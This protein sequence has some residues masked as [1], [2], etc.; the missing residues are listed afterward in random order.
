MRLGRVPADLGYKSGGREGGVLRAG[1]HSLHTRP[2][3]AAARLKIVF[4]N[5]EESPESS[6]NIIIYYKLILKQI[7]PSA[8]ATHSKAIADCQPAVG[9]N[10]AV[11]RG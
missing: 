8:C 1:V 11:V 10:T 9:G 2:P 4:G 7:N 3:G 5:W 6:I